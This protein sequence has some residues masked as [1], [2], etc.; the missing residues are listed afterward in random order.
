MPARAA[1]PVV[2][3]HRASASPASAAGRSGHEA[4]SRR[5]R[6][7]RATPPRRSAGTPPDAAARGR[8]RTPAG[9][10]RREGRC[11]TS[12]NSHTLLPRS[13]SRG[14]LEEPHVHLKTDGLDVSVLL[15]PQHVAGAADLEIAHRDRHPG[16]ELGV[17][18]EG[19]RSRS[20]AVGV[21]RML[22]GRTGTRTPARRHAHATAE[23]V[24]LREPE[25][26][27]AIDDQRVDR[28]DVE[29]RLR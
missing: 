27:G 23:L 8:C 15:G 19:L 25:T 4:R 1:P 10:H 18:R 28:R 6:R 2:A 13:S 9:R 3:R 24:E 7:R 26:V 12:G 16:A 29:T 5:R 17:L 21:S 22:T 14:L 11:C 20:C